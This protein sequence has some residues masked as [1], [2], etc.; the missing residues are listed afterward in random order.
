M[1]PQPPFSMVLNMATQ[2]FARRLFPLGY[3]LYLGQPYAD[4]TD[5][6]ESVRSTGVL[7]VS[8]DHNGNTIYGEGEINEA[9]RAWHDWVHYRY[10]LEFDTLGE[11][12]AAFVQL[13]QLVRDYGLEYEAG[14]LLLI[15]IIGQ[16]LYKD[17]FGSFPADQR[18]F[19]LDQLQAGLWLTTATQLMDEMDEH[20]ATDRVALQMANR[21]ARGLVSY[22][23]ADVR[24]AA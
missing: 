11:V 18:Q 10:G 6:V 16:V 7:M 8:M 15:E 1:H 9:A 4:L 23:L 24:A 2:T 20:E 22:I 12:K 19:A 5:L 14:A 21:D 13:A 17:K 3:E